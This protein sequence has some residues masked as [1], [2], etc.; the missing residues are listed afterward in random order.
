M[1][2]VMWRSALV[3]VA[4]LGCAGSAGAAPL[5]SSGLSLDEVNRADFASKPA[6][7][8]GPVVLKAQVLLDRARFS[9]GVVDGRMGENVERAIAAFEAAEGLHVDGRLDGEVW[10]RLTARSPAPP[11]VEYRIGKGDVKGP[12]ARVIP[13]SFEAKAELDRLS[14]TGPEE[15]LAEKFHMDGALL[16]ALNPGKNFDEPG[17][18]IVVA[19]VRAAAKWTG[20]KAA[21][22]EVDKRAG[23]VR[24][25]AADGR[26]LAV[27]PASVGSEEKPAPSGSHTVRAL[28]SNPTYTYNPDYAFK[29]VEAKKTLKI[30]PGP[31][32][33][34]GTMWIDLSIDSFGVHGTPDPEEVGKA[35]SHGCV[36]LTNWDVEELATMV[37]KGTPVAFLD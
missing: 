13:E 3:I 4:T 31:N 8:T 11:L 12:F 33:P 30:K 20:E 35:S 25:L 18:T 26:V 7:E 23:V 6:E 24:G 36:R 2:Q 10:A 14:Y 32:N 22:V 9:P 34:V 17:T 5:A 29:E 1:D 21:K 37:E 16:Q 15:L 19:N 28:A 27:Y